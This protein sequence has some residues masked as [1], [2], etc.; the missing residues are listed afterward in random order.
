MSI[1]TSEMYPVGKMLGGRHD[2]TLSYAQDARLSRLI[3]DVTKHMH[4]GG[5]HGC[6]VTIDSGFRSQLQTQAHIV[7]LV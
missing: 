1:V 5:M 3:I 6:I 4:A 7:R 2:F